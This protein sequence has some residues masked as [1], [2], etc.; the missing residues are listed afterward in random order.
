MPTGDRTGP[1]GQGPKT[2]RALG[3]CSGYDSPGYTKGFGMNR[4]RRMGFGR[5]PGFGRGRR[6][7]QGRYFGWTSPEFD[8]LYPWHQSLSKEDEIKMLKSQTEAL[9]RTQAELERRI[10]E[11]ENPKD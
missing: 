4:G 9:G 3:F 11:L 5:C 1:L 6:M 2:G 10:Q 7:M 8:Q